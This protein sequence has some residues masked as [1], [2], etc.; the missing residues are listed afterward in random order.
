MQPERWQQIDQLFHLA[1][2]QD[3]GRRSIFLSQACGDD[4]ALR[5][6]VE[7]LIS[8]HERAEEFIEFP[9]ADLAAELLSHSPT[10]LKLDESIGPYK[11]RSV[12]GIGGMGEVYLAQDTRLERQVALKVLPPQFT[13]DP[14]RVRRFEQEARTASAL[15]HP[16]I[17]TIHE[18][19]WVDG[20][21]FIVTEF[22][23]GQTLRQRMANGRLHLN[24]VLEISSQVASAL[25]AAHAAGIVHRDIKPENIM[26]R[27]DG[28]VKVLDFG[29]AKLTERKTT[30]TETA[31]TLAKIQTKSG[32]VLGTVT[33]M[34]PE[35]ARGLAVDAR[36]DIFS[37]G[38][39][40]Y[41]MLAGC[42]P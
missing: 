21:Q 30:S 25:G 11:I 32:L 7:E 36:S 2:E 42:V 16:N 35:Q 8:F 1:L 20:A 18:I 14:E 22:V 26:L 27:A 31:V 17:V 15:N 29:L 41:Q 38:V 23:E 39:V 9:A 28:Y 5:S 19:G 6:E 13:I 4:L 33:Y 10:G 37:L 3:R 24:E 12:L 40:I 34:S